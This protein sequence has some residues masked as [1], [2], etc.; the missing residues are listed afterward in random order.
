MIDA[1]R[2]PLSYILESIFTYKGLAVGATTYNGSTNPAVVALLK[3]ISLRGVKNRV[4]GAFGSFT[5]SGKAVKTISDFAGK[6]NFTVPSASVEMK[7]GFSL[8]TAEKCIQLGLKLG[9]EIKKA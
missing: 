4:F 3:A 7:Q 5:W 1:A 2:T 6:M 8:E 9:E